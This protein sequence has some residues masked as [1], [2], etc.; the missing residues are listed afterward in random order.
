MGKTKR[1]FATMLAAVMVVSMSA[2]GKNTEQQSA[3]Q[4]AI[5]QELRELQQSD[6]RGGVMR[7]EAIK[8]GVIGLMENMKT[9]NVTIR[10]TSPNS[11]WTVDGYQDFVS[12][13]FDVGVIDETQWFNEEETDWDTILAQYLTN[14]KFGNGEKL[15][16]IFTRNEKDDY[17]I[18]KVPMSFTVR[19]ETVIDGEVRQ[20]NAV[21][22]GNAN[23]RILYDCDKDWCK[24]YVTMPPFSTSSNNDRDVSDVTVNLFEYQRVDN[25]TFA[26]QT[27]RE[28]M[29]VVFEPVE[30]DVPVCDRTIKEMYYSK[31]VQEGCRTT[32]TPEEFLQEED[33]LTGEVLEDNIEY[34][35]QLRDTI[36]VNDE[37]DLAFWYGENDSMFFLTPSAMTP[38]WVFEDKSL[39][40]AIC[41]KDGVLV[42]TTYNK[43]S[44]NY[45]RFVYALADADEKI[46]TELE[47]LVEINNLVGLFDES[48]LVEEKPEDAEGEDIT[49]ETTT[50]EETEEPTTEE[51]V[52]ENA[53]ENTS[54]E[55]TEGATEAEETAEETPAVEIPEAQ[56]AVAP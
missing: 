26:I 43:L 48:A 30:T 22:S 50:S 49:G 17:S 38:E 2:C 25:N 37:G 53:T 1:I 46:A 6:Y 47:K 39:Q 41:Y 21:T 33:L 36:W 24:A 16:A 5:S 12:T 35:E 29:L 11:F 56:T 55:T 4:A 32:F 44:T 42:V 23:Y 40:Q 51:S 15:T 20:Y 18:D 45:E 27:S 14:P 19:G 54:E 3:E 9:N 8:E 13:L 31:L 10:Q 28:R 52:S 34:N 7:T